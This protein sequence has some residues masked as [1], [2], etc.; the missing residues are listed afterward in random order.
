MSDKQTI[1]ARWW[2][3][4][5][6]DDEDLLDNLATIADGTSILY[7]DDVMDICYDAQLRIEELRRDRTMIVIVLGVPLMIIGAL[8]AL[9]S[10]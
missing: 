5:T 2:N 4:I 1:I 9:G 10:I 8:I 3:R 6:D 7:A